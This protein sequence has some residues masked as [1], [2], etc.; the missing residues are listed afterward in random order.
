MGVKAEKTEKPILK[1]RNIQDEAVIED[2]QKMFNLQSYAINCQIIAG[3]SLPD[4]E[5]YK[6]QV[7][8]AEEEFDTRDAPVHAK[9]STYCRWQ[10]NIAEERKEMRLPYQDIEDIG[11]IFIYLMQK[12]KI[13]NKYERICYY[14]GH[15]SEF[16]EKNASVTWLTMVPDLAIGDVTDPH[17]AGILGVRLSLHDIANDGPINWNDYPNWKAKMKKRPNVYKVR[18]FCFQARD[19]PAADENGTSDPFVRINDCS[20]TQESKVIF[21]NVN[22]IWY[23]TLELS[24]EAAHLEDIPPIIV[25]LFDMEVKTI[26]S[27]TT[28]FLSRA[29]LRIPDIEPYAEDNSCPTPKWYPLYFNQ[30]GAMS[31][32]ILMSFA[33]VDDDHQFPQKKEAVNLPKE[34][35]IVM[36]EYQI[37]MNILGL[38]NL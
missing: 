29:I 25:D 36:Q 15:I 3:I 9:D 16:L 17:K 6:V 37:T 27:N 28:E 14:R 7:R 35:G 21:D 30:N 34:A 22:P 20:G 13:G 23:Q 24:Y 26:G 8:V 11:S 33:I 18:A 10:E 19:L 4:T 32:E 5:E 2:A 38:R 31:G 12:K 1:L